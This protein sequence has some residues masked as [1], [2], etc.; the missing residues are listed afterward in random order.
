MLDSRSGAGGDARRQGRSEDELGREASDRV[1]DRLARRDIA[2]ERAKALGERALDDVDARGEP[3]SLAQAAAAG[4]IEAD[5]V[6]LVE[7][8]QRVVFFSERCDLSDRR[9]V[10]VH[11]IEA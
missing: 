6:D 2:A 11:R 1:D 8:S 3:F 4:P 9:D 7:V 10:A 5:G